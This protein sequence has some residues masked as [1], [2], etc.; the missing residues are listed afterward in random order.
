M[1]GLHFLKE[2]GHKLLDEYI[3]LDTYRG[4]KTERNHAYQKLATKIRKN[5]NAHFGMMTTEKEVLNANDKLQKM[6]E[7]RKNRIKYYGYDKVEYAP[8]IQELQKNIKFEKIG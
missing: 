1:S 4:P 3:E 5:H 2:I 6:I 8:N 7:K